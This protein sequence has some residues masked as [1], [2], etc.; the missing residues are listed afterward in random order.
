[1]AFQLALDE[2]Q[3]LEKLGA[4]AN[5]GVLITGPPVSASSTAWCMRCAPAAG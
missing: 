4:S 1:M 5:L 2:P 3:L